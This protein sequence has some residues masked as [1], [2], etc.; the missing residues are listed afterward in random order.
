MMTASTRWKTPSAGRK[1]RACKRERESRWIMKTSRRAATSTEAAAES[2][3]LISHQ[4]KRKAKR[5]RRHREAKSAGKRNQKGGKYVY[6]EM[7]YT[8]ATAEIMTFYVFISIRHYLERKA[9]EAKQMTVRPSVCP[10]SL[11]LEQKGQERKKRGKTFSSFSTSPF[12]RPLNAPEKSLKRGEDCDARCCCLTP[13]TYGR[14]TR[15]RPFDKWSRY[16]SSARR[17]AGQSLGWLQNQL[18]GRELNEFPIRL[19]IRWLTPRQPSVHFSS[20]AE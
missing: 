4:T 15:R 2:C 16:F 8:H 5:R 14:A 10:P 9:K 17:R 3:S 12:I 11:L 13:S 20:A 1:Y 18:T 6:L 19:C 7:I